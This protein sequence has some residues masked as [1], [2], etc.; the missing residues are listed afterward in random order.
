MSI[1]TPPPVEVDALEPVYAGALSHRALVGAAALIALGNV[2]SRGLGLVRE[3]V[4]AATFGT[5]GTVDAF[6]VA[7]TVSATLYDLLVGSVVTAAFVPVF[8]QFTGDE[9]RLW[10]LVSAVLSLALVALTLVAA[11]LALFPD[12][13]AFALARGFPAERRELSTQLLRIALISVVFQG[14][15]GVLTSVL[16]AQNRFTLPAFAVATYNAGVIVGVLVLA[17]SL[18]PRALAAG[19]VIG[20]AGQMLLQAAGLRA[21]WPAYRPRVDLS[22][23]AV[24]QVLRLYGPVAAGMVVTIVGYAIDI[25]LA[26]GLSEGSLSAKQY[27]TTLVQFPLGMVGLATSFAVLPTLARFGEGA[28]RDPERYRDALLFG[29]KIILLLMLPALAGLLVLAQPLVQVLFERGAFRASDTGLVATIFQA[30]APQLPFTALDYL[31][32]AAFYARQN[33]RTPVIVG[34]VSVG[35]YLLVAFP[36]LAPLGV[37]GLA[38]AD[39]AKNSAHALILLVLLRRA[40]PHLRLGQAL[41]PF[42]ARVGAATLLM[43]GGLLLARP[44]LAP[45]GPL[46]GL[47]V[48]GV[49]GGLAYTMLLRLLGVP[50]ARAVGVLVRA[51]LRR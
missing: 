31:L 35:V 42:L 41:V 2:L 1:P 47:L 7:R 15:A 27:A 34:V 6:V 22:D 40:L 9:R 30:F 44:L 46:A 37:V 39:A 51:R 38:L 8:V 5:S 28:E 25:N 29:I 16:Y 45:I 11:L 13:V 32:I 19:L 50:E 43:G 23:P 33:T 14:L 10:R 3:Q 24:R 49:V 21:F 17:P 12:A 48:S 36:L 20:A 4:I 18:G 26:S